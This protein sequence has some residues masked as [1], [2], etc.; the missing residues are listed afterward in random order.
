MQKLKRTVSGGNCGCIQTKYTDKV[1][2]QISGTGTDQFK[3]SY[4]DVALTTSGGG[5]TLQEN[6]SDSNVQGAGT[7]FP[8]G[9]RS[10][11][12]VLSK[13]KFGVVRGNHDTAAGKGNSPPAMNPIT[14]SHKRW[15]TL[16]SIEPI[17]LSYL[18]AG[19]HVMYLPGHNNLTNSSYSN[20]MI[21][22]VN[23]NNKC[24]EVKPKQ[25][26]KTTKSRKKELHTRQSLQDPIPLGV[27][28]SRSKYTTKVI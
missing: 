22:T 26:Q 15:N 12:W 17:S 9:Y 11:N 20:K 14:S 13:T 19:K 1:T 25:N 6:T 16:V 2:E 3:T 7:N 5:G 10:D 27:S 24:K 4:D 8:N 21:A 18:T 23:E 28:N